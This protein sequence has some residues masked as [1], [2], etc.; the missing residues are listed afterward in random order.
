[1]KQKTKLQLEESY[2]HIKPYINDDEELKKLCEC[3]EC[4]CGNNHNYED[5]K[6]N[7]CFKMY[8]AYRYLEWYNSWQKAGGRMTK[9]EAAIISAYTGYLIGDIDEMYKYINEIMGRTVFTHEISI[10]FDEIREKAKTDF[11]NIN[12]K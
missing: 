7:Q 3:C 9:R 6:N 11:E 5:C 1:M 2:R 4:Y 10:L 8:L 12:V